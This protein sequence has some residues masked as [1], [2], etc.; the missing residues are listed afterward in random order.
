M[1]VWHLETSAGARFDW[2]K[3]EEHLRQQLIEY[4]NTVLNDDEPDDQ[5]AEDATLE[6]A[7]EKIE[8][9]ENFSQEEVYGGY[10]MDPRERD[11]ILAALRLWQHLLDGH[12]TITG[13]YHDTPDELMEIAKNGDKHEPLAAAEIDALCERINA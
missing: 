6:E 10:L 8:E 2:A 3:D 1:I 13:L 5:L 12:V 9:R 4:N 11:T 7:I